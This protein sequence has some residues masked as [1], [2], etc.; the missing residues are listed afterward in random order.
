MPLVTSGLFLTLGL[1]LVPLLCSSIVPN[2]SLFFFHVTRQT[3]NRPSDC[4]TPS[5]ITTPH[6]L[7]KCTYGCNS[8]FSLYIRV[9]FFPEGRVNLLSGERPPAIRQTWKIVFSFSS[10]Q[11]SA[12][13]VPGVCRQLDD[14]SSAEFGG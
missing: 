7:K 10:K 12:R 1:F 2:Q 6:L 5:Y 11:L 9:N 13:E 3:L 14:R 4:L 8:A